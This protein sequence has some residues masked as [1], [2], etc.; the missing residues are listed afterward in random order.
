VA[1]LTIR[2]ASR[3][4]RL[5]AA[6]VRPANAAGRLPVALITHGKQRDVSE[7][8]RMRAE[9]MLPQARD[10]AHRG[11][12]AVAVVRRGFGRSDGTPGVAENAK[13]V[14]CSVADLTRYFDVEADQLEGALRA[15]MA[16]PDADPAR[17][18]AISSSVGGGVMLALAAR[19]PPGLL[20]AVNIAG[21]VRLTDAQRTLV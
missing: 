10:L 12:L 16:R 8:A 18:I 6:I 2:E 20:A 13:Y 17:A 4:Y 7:M 1:F 15:V 19:K 9:Q 5:E 3:T 21:G 11:Y 14:K